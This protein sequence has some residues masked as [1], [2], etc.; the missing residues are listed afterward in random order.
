MINMKL[1]SPL[2]TDWTEQYLRLHLA[3]TAPGTPLQL[4]IGGQPTAF[5]YTG[6]TTPSGAEILVK[7]GFA[8]DEVKELVFSD[9]YSVISNQ[10]SEK[11][12]EDGGQTTGNQRSEKKTEGRRNIQYPTRNIQHPSVECKEDES[13]AIHER[14]L[15]PDTR[16][17]TEALAKA[18]HLTPPCLERHEIPLDADTRIGIPG[19]QLLIPTLHPQPSPLP[20]PFAGFANFAMNSAIRCDAAFECASL[21]QTN[22][23]SLFTDYELQYCFA[24]NRRYTL[25]FRCYKNDPY[26]E[27]CETFSLRM[28]A[29]LVWT[30]NPEKQ[31]THIISRDSFEGESQPTVEP[32]GVERP[33]DVLCRLQMPVLTEYFIPNNRGWFSFCDIRNEAK[34]MLGIMGLYGAKWE[35][36]VA[37]MPEVLDKGGTVEWHAS[38]ASGKRHWLLYAGKVEKGFRCQVSGVSEGRELKADNRRQMT[39]DIKQCSGVE[40]EVTEKLNLNSEPYSNIQTS[41]NLLSN[42]SPDNRHLTTSPADGRFVFHRLHA[43]FN[44]LRL[45]EHLDLGGETFFDA[46]CATAPGVF[47]AGDYHEAARQ[48]LEQYPCLEN[49][50]TAPDVWLKQNGGMHLASYR[51]LLEPTSENAQALY[52]HLIARFERWVRQFQGYRTGES[53]YMKNVIGFSRYLRGMLLAYEQLRRD[54]A[55]SDEQTRTLNAYF[56]FAARRI[57]DE[58]RW[59]HS[60]TMLHPDHPESSRDFYTYG[61]EH[62]PDRLAWTN[63]LPNFQGDPMCALAHLSA[64]FKDHPD[65]LFWR[66]FAL[67]DIDRQLDAYCGKSGAWE[68][69]INYAL[70]TFSYFVITFK[71]VKER[72]GID[73]FNDERVRRFV[74]WLCRFFGPYDKRFDSY[75]W[76]AIGNAVLPQNQA[77]YLLCY[78]SELQDGDPLKKDCLA[79]WQLCAEKCR[80]GEHYPVVMAAMGPLG[81]VISNQLS[82]ISGE[83]AVVSEQR[84]DN[85][86]QMTDGGKETVV[87]NQR[88]DIRDQVSG[89]SVRKSE[90]SNEEEAVLNIPS[91]PLNT[92][93][94]A[95]RI[96]H[97]TS[98]V[99]DEV[100]VALRDRH[101]QPDE[102]YL[103]QKIG[104]AKDHYEADETAF[105]WYAKGTPLCMDYGTYTGDVAVAGAHNVVEIP[106]EDNLRRGYLARHLFSSLVDYTHCEVPVTLKLLWGKVRTFAEVENKD[107][108]ID[109]TKTPYFYIGDKNP[110][111]PKTWKVRQLLFVKPDYTVLFDR[112]YG[113]VPHRY[114]L[115]FTGT[116]IQVS[117]VRCQVSGVRAPV[118]SGRNLSSLRSPSAKDEEADCTRDVASYSGQ[119]SKE[120]S[121]NELNRLPITDYRLPAGNGALITADGRFDLDLLAYVQHPAEF[122]ME[123][124]EIIPNVHPGCGGE[125][126]KKKHA[127]N[128]FRLYNKKDGI[129]RTLLFAKERNREVRIENVGVCGMKVVTPEYT[130][131]V[132]IHND[133]IDESCDGVRFVGRVGWI[134]RDA[135]GNVQACVPDGDLIQAFG[136]KIEGRGP[137]TYNIDG[138]DGIKLFEGPPRSVRVL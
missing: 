49:V 17:P 13:P 67:E 3:D 136:T 137:W 117:G 42:L 109:R 26:I 32:L 114:N 97:L 41:N 94:S 80:P 68:E 60:R 40:K 127:Q 131:Y 83:E 33:R 6:V 132:F 50:L 10:W 27:V 29:E 73:Y 134:R 45:D 70:Y 1:K 86:G 89:V 65:A 110:V 51:Y 37:N 79:I 93:H 119:V 138:N 8:K 108:K 76:P 56:A 62:K 4:T 129:Y 104:F 90:S 61:G 124:G 11:T 101:T 106:D 18:G 103:F 7:L 54:G 69:S 84:I 21:Y 96:P 12:D 47:A 30:L 34:G 77:E 39:E 115:H 71:A 133:V 15:T 123:T 59:P 87:S 113:Q 38:L 78:A 48:R 24:D 44:A 116:G 23:G 63:C 125:E 98:E 55:L 52:G 36:P 102:S 5:Q 43:E 75:T 85:R 128:Y 92:P 66:R 122:E 57:L 35:E 91:S 105:N 99:M 58:G 81:E 74:G 88:S 121:A 16:L 82:V 53:D 126:A 22:D 2:F 64:I 118:L 19:R 135:K 107:G 14:S 31:F 112:V 20:G 120:C 9:Q 130:D 46:S 100:G 28:N 95:L 25:N 72:W 111:G